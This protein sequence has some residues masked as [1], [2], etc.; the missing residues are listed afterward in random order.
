MNVVRKWWRLARK[1]W[2]LHV[3]RRW[4]KSIRIEDITN[5]IPPL[6]NETLNGNW[7][8]F[9]GDKSR[10]IITL[11][12][13]INLYRMSLLNAAHILARASLDAES[14]RRKMH[15]ALFEIV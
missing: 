5:K 3:S 14:Y 15:F 4:V 8:F 1:W 6:N 7:M 11:N 13:P 2:R 10:Y 9:T 12:K